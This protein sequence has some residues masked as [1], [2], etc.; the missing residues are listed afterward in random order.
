MSRSGLITQK[1]KPAE[2]SCHAPIMAMPEKE[3][4]VVA[5]GFP[6][7]CTACPTTLPML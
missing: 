6:L 1:P 5:T 7:K 3:T 2:S 4:M